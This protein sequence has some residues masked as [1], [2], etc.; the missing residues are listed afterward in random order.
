MLVI[1]ATD[2]ERLLRDI[3]AHTLNVEPS[4]IGMD[5]SFFR[6][7]GDSITAMQVSSSARSQGLQLS[8]AAVLREKTISKILAAQ[9]L[10]N[11]RKEAIPAVPEVRAGESF[12]FY[13]V[14]LDGA[15]SR[16]HVER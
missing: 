10:N 13:K 14:A 5:D 15:A 2:E 16:R 1:A 7:G 9:A 6:L 8:S 11:P 3:W 12:P 4:T